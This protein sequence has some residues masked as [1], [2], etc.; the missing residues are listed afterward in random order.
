MKNT[1]FLLEEHKAKFDFNALQND[2][3]RLKCWGL[4][5]SLDVKSCNPEL[6]RSEECIKKYIYELCDLIQM[7]RFGD[8]LIIFF[9]EDAAVS[10]YSMTQL[11]ETSLISGH[12][13]NQTN[14]AFIDIFSCKLYNPIT[15]ATFTQKYFEAKSCKIGYLF[16]D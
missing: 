8:P 14:G 10:G 13:A 2:Y 16:R 5:T 9:G 3:H 11:I 7:K 15:A 12:F 4:T 1:L 6:I